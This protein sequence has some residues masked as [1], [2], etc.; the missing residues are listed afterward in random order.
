[1]Q[2]KHRFSIAVYSGFRLVRQSDKRNPEKHMLFREF[3][4]IR[5]GGC[6]LRSLG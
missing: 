6:G 3:V 2:S 5:Q 1:M 4:F